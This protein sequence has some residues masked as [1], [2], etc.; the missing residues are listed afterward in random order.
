[1][2]IV[3]VVI[4]GVVTWCVASE[5]VWGAV[6]TCLSVVLGGLL[7][8]NFFEPMA[9]V[10]ERS[11]PGWGN[12]WD[13]VC[14]IGLFIGFVTAFRVATDRISPTFTQTASAFQEAGRWG[15]GFLT[16]YVTMAFLL[17]A[18]HTAPLPREFLGFAPERKNFFSVTAPDRQWLGFTQYVS[19]KSLRK[20]TP[21]FF[22]GPYVQLGDPQTVRLNE[23]IW[24]SFPIRYATRR[25]RYAGSPRAGRPGGGLRSRP[26]SA[27][28]QTG[29][30]KPSF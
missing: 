1:M 28:S 12:Y 25:E 4:L 18:L 19:E 23:N 14:L 30:G 7:A 20:G 2:D 5:G 16:G 26:T 3:L 9:A 8:M 17:T 11:I 21:R 29:S 15:A 24:A 10:M 27:P 6:L 13:I 22:D